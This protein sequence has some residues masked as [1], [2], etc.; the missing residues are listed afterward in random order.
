[1]RDVNM[2]EPILATFPRKW[3]I[4]VG[5]PLP[6]QV[7]ATENLSAICVLY[8]DEPYALFLD[9]HSRKLLP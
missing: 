1:M 5:D 3:H 6:R 7:L 9:K 8:E 4:S 2:K